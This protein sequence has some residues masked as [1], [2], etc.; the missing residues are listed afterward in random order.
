MGC[1]T[2]EQTDSH[3]WQNVPNPPKNTVQKTRKKDTVAC[4]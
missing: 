1:V 4:C 3:H 2:K